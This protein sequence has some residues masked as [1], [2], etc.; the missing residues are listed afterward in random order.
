[1]QQDDQTVVVAAA[2]ARTPQGGHCGRSAHLASA[3]VHSRA[4]RNNRI[5][6][7]IIII[8][9]TMLMCPLAGQ[10]LLLFTQLSCVCVF[11][12]ATP[13]TLHYNTHNLARLGEKWWWWWPPL[14]S[15]YTRYTLL[16]L[17]KSRVMSGKSETRR[18]SPPR[19]PAELLGRN[20]TAR[21][22]LFQE[23]HKKDFM[24]LKPLVHFRTL[25]SAGRET[26]VR[27]YL[28]V[29]LFVCFKVCE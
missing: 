29:C 15:L 21:W 20:A 23:S 18:G 17:R 8:I 3:T 14:S 5:M 1:M 27:S 28:C 4:T 9:I 13:G 25:N 11:N 6:A 26:F 22:W 24:L 7:I 10:L 16:P 19:S 2:T 12:W